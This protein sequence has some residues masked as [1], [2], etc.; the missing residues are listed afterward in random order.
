MTAKRR[1]CSFLSFENK[2]LSKYLIF[3]KKYRNK[4]FVLQVNIHLPDPQ[5]QHQQS[6]CQLLHNPSQEQLHLH[7]PQ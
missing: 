2:I 7:G 3:H 5:L 4:K 6:Q 1:K